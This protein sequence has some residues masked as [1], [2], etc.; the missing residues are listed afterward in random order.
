MNFAHICEF[1]INRAYVDYFCF[2]STVHSLLFI[3]KIYVC[4][5]LTCL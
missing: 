5:V 2:L 4:H 3:Y 1:L